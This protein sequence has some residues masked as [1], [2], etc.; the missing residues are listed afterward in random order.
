[1][2]FFLYPLSLIMYFQIFKNRGCSFVEKMA[3]MLCYM[4]SLM[5][6]SHNAMVGQHSVCFNLR[7]CSVF[8]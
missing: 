7:I 2:L 4:F 6:S 8:M 5:K 3:F 1:M